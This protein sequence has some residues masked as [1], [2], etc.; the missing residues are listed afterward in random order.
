MK[1][2][3][4]GLYILTEMSETFPLKEDKDY[5]DV[6]N[7]VIDNNGGVYVAIRRVG[8]N[9]ALKL[10]VT[11]DMAVYMYDPSNGFEVRKI[12]VDIENKSISSIA[13]EIDPEGNLVGGGF[14][15]ERVTRGLFKYEGIKGTY[16]I[17]IDR[18]E[19]E[20]VEKTLEPFNKELTA[21]ILTEKQAAKGKLVTNHFVP[22]KIILREDGGM[23]LIAEY[24]TVIRREDS[25]GRVTI[26]YTHGPLIVANLNGEGKI[27]WVRSIPKMQVYVK[28]QA[29]AGL[30]FGGISFTFSVDWFG[31]NPNKHLAVYHS[32]LTGI[33]EE[34]LYLVYNDH[35]KN[36]ELEHFRDTK[37]LNGYAKAVPIS[38]KIDGNGKMTKEILRDKDRSEVVLRPGIYHQETYDHVIIFGTR[39]KQDKFG[40]IT[41]F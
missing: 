37:M 13:L 19:E 1:V 4:S 2:L 23:V 36:I 38:I 15:G 22:R 27:D 5:I 12:P 33:S 40:L 21:Q 16:F 32:F 8:W 11:T 7:Y 28:A 24:Y 18:V 26:T 41:F 3:T 29:M 17:K 20:V 6:N 31:F 9:K 10:A 35:A 25:R 14:Y 39:K 30:S 34:D